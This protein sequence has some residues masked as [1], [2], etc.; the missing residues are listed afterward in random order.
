MLG[1][2]NTIIRDKLA[3]AA[4]R[5]L[6]VLEAPTGE[7]RE[8]LEH[9]KKHGG[10]PPEFQ[11]MAR[12]KKKLVRREENYL[13]STRRFPSNTANNTIGAGPIVAGDYDYFGNGIGDVGTAMGYFSLST[14]GYHHTN[15]DKGGKIPTGRGFALYELAVSFNSNA[16]AADI[17]QMMDASELRYEK[18]GGQLTVH[19][20]PVRFWPGGIGVAAGGSASTTVAA[21]TID[22]FGASNGVPHLAAVRRFKK[23]RL[24]NAN[25]SFRYVMNCLANQAKT[26]AAIALSDFVEMTVWL[27]GFHYDRVPE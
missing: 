8:Q 4:R 18:Q 19:H 14:L 7:I 27:F 1:H 15:M 17:A 21:T 25:D 3:N 11:A 24:L 9:H 22:R 26:N 16:A 13:Y 23:P 20:G 12:K 6:A 5:G 2:I 10:R